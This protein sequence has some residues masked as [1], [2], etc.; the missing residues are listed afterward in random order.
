MIHLLPKMSNFSASMHQIALIDG[1]VFSSSIS[2]QEMNKDYAV[3][4]VFFN[5]FPLLLHINISNK[6]KTF[7]LVKTDRGLFLPS[8]AS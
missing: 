8:G 5:I 1:P 7:Q 2:K 3:S 6:M 4:L